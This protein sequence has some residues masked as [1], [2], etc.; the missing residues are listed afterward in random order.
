MRRWLAQVYVVLLTRR[1]LCPLA[2]LRAYDEAIFIVIILFCFFPIRNY[3][4]VSVHNLVFPVRYAAYTFSYTAACGY[5][6][7]IIPYFVKRGWL[8]FVFWLFTST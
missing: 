1:F 8:N 5:V 2:F 6:D 7:H 4:P 3:Y